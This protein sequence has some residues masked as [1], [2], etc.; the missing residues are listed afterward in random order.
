MRPVSGLVSLRR[1]ASGPSSSQETA[2]TQQTSDASRNGQGAPE[3]QSQESQRSD[4]QTRGVRFA[5]GTTTP[6][7]SAAMRATPPGGESG[8]SDEQGPAAAN[9]LLSL[10]RGR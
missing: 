5:E 1:Q 9:G 4:G 8:A 7:R 6:E 10:A 3:R 2:S